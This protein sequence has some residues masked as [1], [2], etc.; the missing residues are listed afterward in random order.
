VRGK[1]VKGLKMSRK[2]MKSEMIVELFGLS[3]SE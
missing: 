3:E 1:N 2:R